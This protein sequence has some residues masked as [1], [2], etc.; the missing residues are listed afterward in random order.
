MRGD[1][2]STFFESWTEKF[3][4]LFENKESYSLPY[5]LNKVTTAS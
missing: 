2:S 4:M 1:M 5:T 3:L